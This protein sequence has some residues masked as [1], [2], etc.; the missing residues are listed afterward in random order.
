MLHVDK[1]L[2]LLVGFTIT[3]VVA[4]LGYPLVGL[5]DTVVDAPGKELYD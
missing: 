5:V 3:L 4:L 1:L 2:H